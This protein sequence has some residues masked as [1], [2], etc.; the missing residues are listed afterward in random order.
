MDR[1]DYKKVREEVQ[2][3]ANDAARASP[4]YAKKG[5]CDFGL[6]FNSLFK[7]YNFFRLPLPENRCGHELRCEV[8]MP[9]INRF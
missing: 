4:A 9:E 5:G 6:E 1:K 2:K 7:E 8:V 3:M